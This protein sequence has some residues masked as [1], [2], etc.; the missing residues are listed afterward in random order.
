MDMNW[1]YWAF[2]SRLE[3]CGCG[4]EIPD[5]TFSLTTAGEDIEL[6]DE[7]EAAIKRWRDERN[8]SP[9]GLGR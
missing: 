4:G 8:Y 1:V 3:E 7:I 5:L 9:E 6:D 2:I